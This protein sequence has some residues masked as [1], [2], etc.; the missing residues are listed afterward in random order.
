M[1]GAVRNVTMAA[2]VLSAAAGVAFAQPCVALTKHMASTPAV[3]EL[4]GYSVSLSVGGPS[5]RPL[6]A[7]GRP[8]LDTTAGIRAGGWSIKQLGTNGV[9]STVFES[10][11]TAALGGIS[12]ENAGISIALADPYLIVG[13]PEYFDRGRARVFERTPGTNNW[14]LDDDINP[15]LVGGVF[16]SG[17]GR[18]V[19]ISTFGG[20]WAIIGAPR[21]NLT[22][23]NGGAVYVMA[24]D[25][26][27]GDWY[28]THISTGTEFYGVYNGFRGSAVAISQ[29]SE[30]GVW[31]AP[32][33]STDAAARPE[34]GVAYAM[35]RN[36]FAPTVLEP[37]IEE[38]GQG[39]GS[40]VA[41]SGNWIAVGAY[42]EDGSSAET[43]LTTDLTDSGIVYF[44]ERVANTW[45][46]RGFLRAPVP[47]TYGFFGGSLSMTDTQLVV[48]EGGTKRAYVYRRS[49]SNWIVQSAFEDPELATDSG[50]ASRVAVR[51]GIIAIGDLADDVNGLADAGAVYTTTVSPTFNGGDA[52]SDAIP[53]TAGS[54]VGCTETATRSLGTVTTCG[55]GPVQGPDVW[56]RFAPECDGNAIFDTFGSDFDTVLSVHSAC[57]NGTNASSIACND[58]GG[59]AAPNNRASLVSVN[60]QGGAVYY[61]RVAGYNGQRGQFTLRSNLTS[62]VTND[63]CSTATNVV[64][65]SRS[66]STCAAT[67]PAIPVVPLGS[68]R[69]IWFRFIAPEASTY[70]FDTCGSSF[71]TVITLFQGSQIACPTSGFQMIG[72]NDD[73]VNGCVG[74]GTS[75][76]SLLRVPLTA[77][78]S[79]LVRIGGANAGQF[80]QGML[81]ISRAGCDDIDFNNN[82]VYPE[83]QDVIDFFT[84]LSGGACSPGNTCNDIDFNNNDVYPE[85]QDVM[86]FFN[87]LAG[88]E[89]L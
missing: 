45:T 22:H 21:F 32:G 79:V 18:N 11:N 19:A 60:Y 71:D 51:D 48:G 72:Q 70:T 40:A 69:D 17:F 2:A 53:L 16:T 62:G 44:F 37:I 26:A 15:G 87:V 35:G 8:Y 67:T 27:A 52:C 59:F 81:R 7:I 6:L 82:T 10:A 50:Y 78:Q 34:E 74:G 54:F 76:Q 88:G 77:N 56:F 20:P 4:F 55:L 31:G 1:Q 58:D 43:G 63:S 24:R 85:D 36:D 41:A 83:D 84:V 68:N 5:N 61:V 39:F 47:V 66:F 73:S 49:G 12:R 42:A 29:N 64:V 38:A 75:P 28:T 65:G 86:D 57:P 80:G 3:E 13:A 9:W 30:W 23:T 46:P 14:T 89:C 25:A 33:E